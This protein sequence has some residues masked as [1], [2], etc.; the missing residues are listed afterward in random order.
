[1]VGVR[2]LRRMGARILCDARHLRELRRVG[3]IRRTWRN[4]YPHLPNH[5]TRREYTT[6][7]GTWTVAETHQANEWLAGDPVPSDKEHLTYIL[8]RN[9][10]HTSNST[11]RHLSG[12][13]NVYD[14]KS[15]QT[16]KRQ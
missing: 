14:I 5:W 11:V 1:M 16:G 7:L 8:G 15:N 2:H 9:N 10:G 4:L 6:E 3:A 12:G 13:N